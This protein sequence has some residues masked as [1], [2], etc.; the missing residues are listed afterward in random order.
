MATS[1]Q[2]IAQLAIKTPP[3]SPEARLVVI[4]SLIG[5]SLANMD[6][7]FFTWAYPSIQQEFN[8]SLNQVSYLYTAIFI[9][10]RHAPRA[11]KPSRTSAPR[12][13]GLDCHA[14]LFAPH[15]RQR[16]KVV[17]VSSFLQWEE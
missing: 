1:N 14:M 5:W 4:T 17:R 16:F 8:I 7:S 11:V 10:R 2:R 13:L 12:L 3:L 6:Q 9:A 15:G